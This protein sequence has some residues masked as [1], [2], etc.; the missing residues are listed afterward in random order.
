M[1]KFSIL[2]IYFLLLIYNISFA[3]HKLK[4]GSVIPADSPWEK[5]LNEY[6]KHVHDKSAGSIQIKTYLGGQLGGEVEMIKSI[7]MGTLH[8]GAFSTASIAEALNIPELLTFE[9]PFLFNNDAEA[10]YIM[11]KVMFQKMSDLMAKKGLVLIMWGT[12]GWRCFGSNVKPIYSPADLKG[13]KMRSQESEM[14][15]N[16]YK[17]I[18]ASPIPIATP[19]V[20]VSLKTG[21]VNGFDQTPI[22]S[23]STSW[24]TA[25]K[26]FTLSKHVYQPGAIVLSKRAFDKMTAQEQQI[27]LASGVKDN[28]VKKA[29]EYVRVED[30]EI[31]SSL[32]ATYKVSVIELSAAQREE[33][34]KTTKDVYTKLEVKIG[35]ELTKKIQSELT[36]F[37][38]QKK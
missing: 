1:K 13:V 16:F 35:T 9:L 14:Y 3:Q 23:A 17:A 29:R 32:A 36:I 11:D 24:I 5:G 26:Y 15:I 21:M 31:T 34:K 28:L 10:D 37:R 7:A 19:D 4:F 30:S 25:V 27:I 38:Q 12:N 18:G 6:I 20:L 22:F 8:G 33:F 2:L